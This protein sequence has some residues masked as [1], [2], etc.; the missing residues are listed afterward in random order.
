VPSGEV[1][2]GIPAAPKLHK[3]PL[4]QRPRHP[5]TVDPLATE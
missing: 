2:L 1:A 5:V 3:P 4:E